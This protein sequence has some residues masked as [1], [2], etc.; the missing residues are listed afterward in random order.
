LDRHE[1][2]T[3]IGVSVPVF[4]RMVAEGTL[5]EPAELGGEAIWDLVKLDKAFDTLTGSTQQRHP[6]K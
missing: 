5:P 3:Y 2:A 4:D 6:W 1:A